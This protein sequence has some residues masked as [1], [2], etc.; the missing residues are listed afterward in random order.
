MPDQTIGRHQKPLTLRENLV[1]DILVGETPP[2]N[3]GINTTG[4][5]VESTR[6]GA[7]QASP[8]ST[9]IPGSVPTTDRLF[10]PVTSFERDGIGLQGRGYDTVTIRGADVLHSRQISQSSLG[11]VLWSGAQHLWEKKR[12]QQLHLWAGPCLGA[13]VYLGWWFLARS[14]LMSCLP[15]L[16]SV[17][18]AG[19]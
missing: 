6:G 17:A 14:P 7:R 9:P 8:R 13:R 12:N 5:A 11:F 2:V 19:R 4:M 16:S 1:R 10:S 3:A 18:L 15:G